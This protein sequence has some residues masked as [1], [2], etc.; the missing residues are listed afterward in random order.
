MQ[1][2][3]RPIIPNTW[4]K[5]LVFE[6]QVSGRYKLLLEESNALR[7]VAAELVAEVLPGSGKEYILKLQ[8]DCHQFR[9]HFY[10]LPC[11]ISC[12]HWILFSVCDSA[13]D[14]FFYLALLVV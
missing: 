10:V 13:F 6:S 3:C 9:S 1:S 2:H 8:V 7:N 12:V 4:P 5:R 11:L 14:R